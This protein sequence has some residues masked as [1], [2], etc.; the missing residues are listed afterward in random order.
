MYVSVDSL[1]SLKILSTSL[2]VLEEGPKLTG[3]ATPAELRGP[4]TRYNGGHA[5]SPNSTLSKK[6]R[7][8]RRYSGWE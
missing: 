1:K 7:S 6:P 3:D 2:T 5:A 4:G 8:L